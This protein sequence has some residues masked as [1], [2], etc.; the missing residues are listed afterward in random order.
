M[1]IF[2][3]PNNSA[4]MGAVRRER[5]GVASSLLSLTRTM[6]QTVGVAIIGALWAGQVSIYAGG[7]LE[8]G[9]TAA[10][11]SAQVAGLNDTFTMISVF[12]SLALLLSLWGLVQERRQRS[13]EVAGG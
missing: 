6:G 1:G 9:A 8:A 4:I 12:V 3:S 2:Q 5:L 10:P 7:L 11:A 13:A